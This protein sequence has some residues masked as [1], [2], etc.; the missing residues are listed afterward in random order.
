MR[1]SISPLRLF[2]GYLTFASRIASAAG[3]GLS[4]RVLHLSSTIAASHWCCGRILHA[5]DW[6]TL[7]ARTRSREH[8]SE[9]RSESKPTYLV[10][11]HMRIVVGGRHR[12]P[13][14]TLWIA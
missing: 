1:L 7:D 5:L 10:I 3:V 13:C 4:L 11:A 8:W 12:F 2:K 14:C 9:L 6:T